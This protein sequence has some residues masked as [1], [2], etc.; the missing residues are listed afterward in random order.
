[1]MN[2]VHE[3]VY[4]NPYSRARLM[5]YVNIL[6]QRSAA[7]AHVRHWTGIVKR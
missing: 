6:T 2:R 3:E 4:G 7:G 1:M 5:A